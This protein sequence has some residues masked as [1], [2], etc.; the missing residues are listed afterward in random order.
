MSR[1]IHGRF[2]PMGAGGATGAINK[3][4]PCA[5]RTSSQQGVKYCSPKRRAKQ[6][7]QAANGLCRAGLRNKATIPNW[8]TNA[9]PFARKLAKTPPHPIL[10]LLQ[11]AAAAFNPLKIKNIAKGAF[12]ESK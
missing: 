3:Q 9:F 8:G 7:R 11:K 12:L 5:A 4:L 1:S 6:Q 10:I 2:T